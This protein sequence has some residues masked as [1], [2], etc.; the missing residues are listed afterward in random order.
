MANLRYGQYLLLRRQ[1]ENALGPLQIAARYRAYPEA[2]QLLAY[3]HQKCGS[4]AQAQ[5]VVRAGVLL[6][7]AD[8]GLSEMQ[9]QLNAATA[10][11]WK[12]EP[13]RAKAPAAADLRAK[14]AAGRGGEDDLF[15]LSQH[16]SATGQALSEEL[17]R[18]APGSHRALQLKA[19][20]AEYAANWSEAER[21]YRQVLSVRPE[22][23]GAHSSLGVVL[24]AQGKDAE[25][26]EQF[27]AE[28]ALDAKN[29]F[30]LFQ[31]GAWLL[32][33][34]ESGEAVRLLNTARALRP[35]FVPG[36]LELGKALLQVNQPAGAATHLEEVIAVEPKH[37][38]AHFLLYRAYLSMG[39]KDKAE[40]QI[41][42]HKR[43][44]QQRG[45]ADSAG[46]R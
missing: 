25:A 40:A 28:L 31:L 9:T 18:L 33:H 2:F 7:P 1:P 46:M 30:A 23:P 24:Q 17:E 38:S 27:R 41:K 43:L 29:H 3:A 4:I 13:L 15:L 8:A 14:L 42:L 5:A 16:Y 37:P 39:I 21:L 10:A 22:L 20:S 12:F 36:L 11:P 35:N 45:T 19:L 26:A 6:F 44:L 34:G 32:R